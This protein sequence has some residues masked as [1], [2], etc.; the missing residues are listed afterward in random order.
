[1][2]NDDSNN[3][4]GSWIV[5]IAVALI[6]AI[7][8]VLVAWLSKPQF[9]SSPSPSSTA[10][11]VASSTVQNPSPTTSPSS[12]IGTYKIVGNNPREGS[13]RGTLDITE[14]GSAYQLIWDAGEQP[15]IG[16]GILEGNHFA[17]GWGNR[18]CAV[19]SYQVQPDGSLDGK[20]A[21]SDQ[22]GIG[23]ELAV[24]SSGIPTND[25]ASQYTTTGK[26]PS[27]LAYKEVMSVQTMGS[28]YQ[29][30]W[31]GSK[32]KGTGIRK[33]NTVAVGLGSVPCN[34]VL[35]QVQKDGSLSGFWGL[36]NGNQA[37]TEEAIR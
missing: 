21:V 5:P 36:Y 31:M 12:I 14:S 10:D 25:I 7:S 6:G 37:G 9:D 4:K 13:Y 26:S 28:L 20:W 16:I 34:V 2:S 29:F 19:A 18:K 24:P 30:S 23:L 33:G 22:E 32:I 15:Y 35:Y 3:K 27:G 11:P 1:M 8:T 17:V